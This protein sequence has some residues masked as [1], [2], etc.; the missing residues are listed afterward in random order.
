MKFLDKAA[1]FCLGGGGYVGLELLYRGYSHISMFAAGGVC[2]LLLGKLEQKHLP[3]LLRAGAG[4]AV[5][6]AVELATGLLVNRQYQVWDYRHQPGNLLG[7]ICPLFCVLWMP[8]SL[9]AMELYRLS[10]GLLRRN[11]GHCGEIRG[12]L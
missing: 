11:R 8:L 6:T 9:A 5:I 2:F 10:T 12:N 1:L 7:Q 4:S 3:L